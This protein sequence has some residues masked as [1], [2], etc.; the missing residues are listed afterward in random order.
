MLHH[1]AINKVKRQIS[2]LEEIV[3]NIYSKHELVFFILKG[4]Y[5]SVRKISTSYEEKKVKTMNR[6]GNTNGI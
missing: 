1:N 4:P 5:Q 6:K 3:A 2:Y